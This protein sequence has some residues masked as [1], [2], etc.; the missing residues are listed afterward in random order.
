MVD[1][2]NLRDINWRC[3]NA[4][5][6]CNAVFPF[7][8]ATGQ[9]RLALVVTNNWGWLAASPK[10]LRFAGGELI[11]NG[12]IENLCAVSN[13]FL[14]PLAKLF[15]FDPWWLVQ[16]GGVNL[17]DELVR[18]LP[19]TNLAAARVNGRPVDS[20]EFDDAMAAVQAVHVGS[21]LWARALKGE[22]LTAWLSADP[23]AGPDAT[24]LRGATAPAG[25][26]EP[27]TTQGPLRTVAAARRVGGGPRVRIGQTATS[28][29]AAAEPTVDEAEP[30]DEQD[31]VDVLQAPAN[32]PVEPPPPPRQDIPVARV[33]DEPMPLPPPRTPAIPPE[34]LA[35]APVDETLDQTI[36]RI[37]RQAQ[38]KKRRR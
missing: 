35:P 32:L 10:G 25:L 26:Y 28:R 24:L 22:S 11:H 23:L 30:F 3:T 8:D 37:R 31:A 33:V 19:K 17:T 16:P 15:H 20:V 21:A 13:R 14:G 5:A 29:P 9:V 38:W 34:A 1:Q 2:I 18:A 6:R 36:Q 4:V 7:F 27:S 12:P